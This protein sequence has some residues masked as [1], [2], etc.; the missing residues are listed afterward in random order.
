MLNSSSQKAP[1]N[2]GNFINTKT[3][4]INES[5]NYE[6]ST[7]QNANDILIS[8]QTEIVWVLSVSNDIYLW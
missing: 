7:K 4:C 6:E 3:S 1:N 5:T 2:Q 8:Y